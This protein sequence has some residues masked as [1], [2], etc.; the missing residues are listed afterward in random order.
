MSITLFIY[1]KNMSK[2]IYLHNDNILK[3]VFD[4]Y[5]PRNNID[6]LDR[7]N[8]ETIIKIILSILSFKKM[9]KLIGKNQIILKERDS[10]I[11]SAILLS[12][13]LMLSSSY[14][15]ILREWDLNNYS[16]VTTIQEETHLNSLLKLP[17]GI[18]ALAYGR[19]IKTI[20]VNDGFNCIKSLSFEGY[21]RYYKL[22][23]LTDSRM[24]FTAY[25]SGIQSIVITDIK[26]DYNIIKAID[27]TEEF[28]NPIA[29]WSNLMVSN[30][31]FDYVIT[32]WDICDTHNIT[33]IGKLT[34][35]T[36]WLI[37]ILY[38]IKRNLL[39]WIV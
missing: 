22:I 15:G 33:H 17:D 20:N 19:A 37:N 24:A 12:E 3:L 11:T 21:T 36:K 2:N 28:I 27:K 1:F 39:I 18:L 25:R 9:F 29:A 38:C 32:V 14:N 6:L 35:H 31:S 34:G 10:W 5:N 16:C 4:N 30:S 8:N 23:L 7:T 26:N 13:N